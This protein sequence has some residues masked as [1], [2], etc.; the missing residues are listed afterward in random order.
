MTPAFQDEV[1]LAGWSETHTGG[2]KVT[3]WLPDAEALDVFRTLTARKGNTAGHRFACVL[4]EIADDEQ[5][6]QES[7]MGNP[8]SETKGRGKLGDLCWRAV[9]WCNDPEFRAFLQK[10][11]GWAANTP[12]EARNAICEVC[13]VASRKMLDHSPIAAEKFNRLIRGPYQKH[14]MARGLA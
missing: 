5:P 12:E 11:T 1:Q 4:V 10:Q 14:L 3:F 7:V 8:I 6:V 13:D 2:A 9:Q